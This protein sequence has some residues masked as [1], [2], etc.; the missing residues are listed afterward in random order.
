M[1]SLTQAPQIALSVSFWEVKDLGSTTCASSVLKVSAVTLLTQTKGFINSCASASLAQET[2][3]ESESKPLLCVPQ[4]F[5]KKTIFNRAVPDTAQ[6][7]L[8]NI[9]SFCVGQSI[10]KSPSALFPPSYK[11]ERCFTHKT[12]SS[13]YTIT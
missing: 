8:L 7:S 5:L 10:E 13:F 9:S 4:P 1:Y 2:L 3:C 11:L 12:E 6:M